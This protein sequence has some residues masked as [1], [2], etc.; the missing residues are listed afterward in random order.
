[1][2]MA[3]GELDHR[4]AL[5]GFA[6][7]APS[8]PEHLLDGNVSPDALNIDYVDGTI[9]KRG[10]VSRLSRHNLLGGGLWVRRSGADWSGIIETVS[11]FGVA[12]TLH[13]YECVV[14]PLFSAV[15]A[16]YQVW[17]HITSSTNGT[18]LWFAEDSGTYYYEA[19]V[20]HSGGTL[21]VRGASCSNTIPRVVTVSFDTATK[22]LRLQVG[23][24]A[25]GNTDDD[26]T[27]GA[28][29]Y[30]QPAGKMRFGGE[31]GHDDVVS[32]VISDF[33]IWGGT[34][35]HTLQ[36]SLRSLLA[37]EQTAALLAW[38][39]F[40]QSAPLE[41][42]SGNGETLSV[43][44]GG[45]FVDGYTAGPSHAPVLSMTGA[46]FSGFWYLVMAAS[47]T[48]VYEGQ[49][50]ANTVMAVEARLGNYGPVNGRGPYRTQLVPY[51]EYVVAMNGYGANVLA[52]WGGTGG[53]WLSLPAPTASSA[54]TATPAGSG[55]SLSAGVYQYLYS[56]YNSTTGVES[57]VGAFISS[58][59][60]VS[61][62]EITLDLTSGSFMPDRYFPGVDEIRIY[63]TVAG[64][65][66]YYYLDAVAMDA[67]SYVDDLA[68]AS[69]IDQGARPLFVGYAAPSRFGFEMDDRLWLGNQSG[70]ESRLVYTERFTLAAFYAENYVDVGY[71][72]GDELTGAYGVADRAVAFKRRSLWLV[73]GGG[74]VS[75]Y[76]LASGVGC[77]Q[78]ATIAASHDA[79]F[80]MGEGGV[81]TMP[82]PLGSG[83][84]LSLTGAQWRTF[85]AALT[86][87]DYES[88]S[89]VWDAF[90]ERYLLSLT[91]GGVRK[92]LVYTSRTQ[93]WALWDCDLEGFTV[94]SGGGANRV[95]CGWRGYL[96]E[97]GVGL[98]DGGNPHATS[99]AYSGTVTG[100]GAYTLT[101]SA[102]TWTAVSDVVNGRLSGLNNVSV[103]VMDAD[104]ENVQTRTVVDNTGTELTVSEAW[105]ENPAAGWTY[106]LGAIEGR[107]RSPLL[108]LERWDR[109]ARLDRV[110][111]LN[112]PPSSASGDEST[113]FVSVD[114][115][116]E[117]TFVNGADDRYVELG[118]RGGHGRE[119]V[120][121]VRQTSADATFEV[122]AVVLPFLPSEGI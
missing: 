80:W 75:V 56:L 2:V 42:A 10:G 85:F 71:G 108:G 95:Y 104:G 8:V 4:L 73:T 21:A 47:A 91:V 9:R 1:M 77:V 74:E 44:G 26:D 34:V 119:C 11:G 63:R 92:V 78:H 25:A 110:R 84:P 103:T 118:V 30:T 36:T 43:S 121:G 93:A 32:A 51:R 15:G 117:E 105:D 101:D 59:T 113:V 86:D 94:L 81:Y 53:S 64:G 27:I 111:V 50:R 7:E 33:R 99:H 6:G 17:R 5:Q 20:Q 29:T 109:R 22:T 58:A 62:D 61:N 18:S 87:A 41:D 49:V 72:D 69:L 19:R 67:T 106:M 89:G 107:W 35:A 55:G 116:A 52:Q 65:S 115:G 28:E 100:G 16:D 57:A 68:D 23:G 38:W 45:L 14:Q 12:G 13:T 60:A 83:S 3:S 37:S 54:P 90:Q 112:V 88:C 39:P 98:N 70:N 102:A 24:A 31:S 66:E 48:T 46:K 76:K 97:L 96:A 120:V 82:L 79:L 40:L 122:G 114:S